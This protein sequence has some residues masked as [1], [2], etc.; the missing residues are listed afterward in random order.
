MTGLL[1]R[2]RQLRQSVGHL[3]WF[4]GLL[5][6]VQRL[7][8]VVNLY[9]TMF[10]LPHVLS[11][12]EL[13]A[14]DPVVRLVGFAGIPLGIV[15]TVGAK[16]LSTYHAT[17]RLGRIKRFMRD[18]SLLGVGS[19]F[20]FIAVLVWTFPAIQSRLGVGGAH[21]L[22]GLC[23]YAFVAASA[24]LV[25]VMLQGMRLFYVTAA[26]GLADPIVR[27]TA[28]LLLVPAFHLAGYLLAVFLAGAATMLIGVLGI[29]GYLFG[30]VSSESYYD[31]L[32]AMLAYALP[33][34]I[35][36]AAGAC[37]GFIEPFTV[38]HFLPA[39]DA[40][41]YFIASRFGSIPGY[42]V[43]AVGFVV[44]PL[45]SHRHERGEDTQ[46]ILTQSLLVTGAVCLAGTVVLG[47]GARWLLALR[48]D[49]A[50]Y[51]AYAPAI[52]AF[53]VMVTLQSLASIYMTH[54]MACRRFTFLWVTVPLMVLESVVLY[55]SFGWAALRPHLPGGLWQVVEDATPHTLAFALGVMLVA[56]FVMTAGLWLQWERWKRM[57]RIEVVCSSAEERAP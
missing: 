13:G 41:G 25:G 3:W 6:V 52:G 31:D 20:V 43:G 17:G 21:L 39:E 24:P 54:E 55:G 30:N 45:L 28:V 47:L 19:S 36:A 33:V 9:V 38:K 57:P 22:L 49:W 44:F 11:Q 32:R 5:F 46:A 50:R 53:G 2:L 51:L 29:R 1:T 18:M 26:A 56:R 12:N 7:G 14:V 37:F 35:G 15:S 8:D 16:Y 23:A 4:T 48:A 34:A 40:A 10:V 27:L 42:L